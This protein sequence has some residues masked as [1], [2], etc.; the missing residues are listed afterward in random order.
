MARDFILEIGTEEMPARVIPSTLEQLEEL[1]SNLFREERLVYQ[2]LVAYATP[3][4]LVLYVTG[5]AEEQ[6]ELVKEVKGPPV[7]TAFTPEGQP[8]RAALGFAQS[9]GVAVEEL[10]IRS[11]PGGDYVFAIKK[12]VGRPTLEALPG[13][14]TKL[15]EGLNFPRPMRWGDLDWRFIRPVRWLL[16]LFGSE[17]VPWELAGLKADRFT[18]GHRFLAPGP[19]PVPSPQ[20][21][22]QVLEKNYVIVDHRRRRQLIWQQVQNLAQEANGR[23]EEDPELLEEITFLVEYPTALL[24]RIE[25]KYLNLPEEVVT[26]PMRGHQRYFP[27]RDGQGKL[28][29]LFIAVHNGTKTYVDNIRPGYEKVLKARLADAAFFYQE[30]RKSP[31]AS[32]VAKLKEI[33]FQE[34]LGTMLDKT[35]RIKQ[36]SLYLA[37]VLDLP[38]KIYPYIERTAEL[39]KADLVTN[40]VYEFPE[41]QGIMGYYYATADGEEREVCEGIRQHYWPRF[42]GDRIPES[43][44]GMVVG[45]ADRLDTLVGCFACGL[46]PTGSQDPYG[47]RRQALGMVIM[48]VELGLKFSLTEAISTA[49]KTYMNERI[50]LP[51]SLEEVKEELMQFFRGRMEYILSEKGVRYDVADAVLAV[52]WDDLADSY[53]R[54][55]DLE[56]FRQEGDFAGLHT[57]FTR[58]FNLARQAPEKAE[59]LEESCLTEEAERRLYL[60]LQEAR[61]KVL[62]YLAQGDYLKALQI[63]TSLREP[64]DVFF[65][66]VLVMAPDPEVRRNRLA[67]LQGV[68][69]LVLQVADFSR[70]VPA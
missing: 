62:P 21:Y 68:T 25:E 32:K 35:R 39:A 7:R 4:R 60:A 70:L 66:K 1:A 6:E 17:V 65:D 44:T 16:A 29:P 63:L 49:Y 9:Q 15:V 51:R 27:V 13:I 47:L 18:Y 46:I 33:L 41:L 19:H 54:A 50:V 10:V 14:L 40:M 24:G 34:N 42:S 38:D 43:L 45:L 57:A 31:L 36:L 22:F 53:A 20:A 23:V 56:T 59:V 55:R 26:T 2:N 48:A 52:G 30:D 37:R 69:N 67:L 28:L 58:A 12:E 3:R 8:T 11:L 61:A 5:L 64:I